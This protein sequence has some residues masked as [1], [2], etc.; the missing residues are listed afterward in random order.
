MKYIFLVCFLVLTAAWVGTRL[1]EPDLRSEVPVIY[2]VAGGTETRLE[3]I[4]TFHRWQIKEGHGERY[5]LK[6]MDELNAFRG[7]HWTP[8][9]I[10]AM[11]RSGADGEKVWSDTTTDADLPLTVGVPAVEMRLDAATGTIDK[12]L[13][14]GLSGVC[15][16]VVDTYGGGGEMRFLVATGMLADLDDSA[17]RMGFDL[18]QTYPTVGPGMMVDGKQYGF[19][20]NV[21][22]HMYWVNKETFRKYDQPLPPS[23]WTL[24]EFERRGKAFVAAVPQTGKHREVFFASRVDVGLVRRSLGV[25]IFNETMTRCTLNDPRYVRAMK[26]V[27]KWMYEDNIVPSAADLA[28]FSDRL[29]ARGG[30]DPTP[31]RLLVDG[32]Y[33][34][35]L[36]GRWALMLYREMATMQLA[37]SEPPYGLF[38]CTTVLGGTTTLYKKSPNR[39]LAELFFA[40]LASEDFNM[41]IVRDG[42]GLPPNPK[43]A[44]TPEFLRPPDYPNEWGSHEVWANSANTIGITP[45]MSPFVLP[46]TVGRIYLQMEEGYLSDRSPRRS[47]EETASLAEDRINEEIERTLR[48]RTELVEAYER[49]VRQQD[50]I[51]RLREEGKKVPLKLIT[52]PFHR[53]Y[54]VV[55]G[56]AEEE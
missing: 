33:A 29:R 51:E 19:P 27:H 11:V 24:D 46:G 3:Q 16:D 35:H 30:S 22:Q 38:P 7:R 52:N 6:T 32:H 17:R 43:F 50:E 18:S 12:K 21:S 36:S 47:A 53:R 34:L 39:G 49:L 2:W 31:F 14:Q 26:L 15:G 10:D 25:S 8:A 4:A 1:S 23:R 55:M 45:S 20:R 9:L 41:Q 28:N 56:W 37:V 40:Y 44:Q 42:D 13:I 48:E 5:T 54:Y